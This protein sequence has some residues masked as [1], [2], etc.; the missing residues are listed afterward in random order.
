MTVGELKQRIE[1]YND[2][3]EVMIG[4]Y[5]NYGSDFAYS[6]DEIEDEKMLRAFYGDDEKD[7]I[8][9]LEGYQCGTMADADDWEE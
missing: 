9:L 2:D 3:T 5:Q 8:F 7:V 1:E 6:V 4:V